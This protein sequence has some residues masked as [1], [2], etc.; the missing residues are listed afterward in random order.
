MVLITV[1][2]SYLFF[3]ILILL[4]EHWLSESELDKLHF[5]SFVTNS[6]SGF[7][8]SSLL[9]G[10]PF[11]GCAILAFTTKTWLKFLLINVCLPT[12]Y[13]TSNTNAFMKKLLV[14]YVVLW[15]FHLMHDFLIVAG[16][17]TTDMHQ[18]C[19]LTDIASTFL[20][21][22]Q[23]TLVDLKILHLWNSNLQT[24]WTETLD[25]SKATQSWQRVGI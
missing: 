13:W 9:H 17:W 4:Q 1:S 23:L 12:D 10:H 14:I 18:S 24:K 8:S 15:A 6:V 16:D 3:L 20:L 11:G 25:T 21:E 19:T 7:D 5:H 22:L 2:L